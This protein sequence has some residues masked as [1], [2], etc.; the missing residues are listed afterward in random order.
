MV[1]VLIFW[2]LGL[3]LGFSWYFVVGDYGLLLGLWFELLCCCGLCIDVDGLVIVPFW[4][5]C[6]T[7]CISRVWVCFWVFSGFLA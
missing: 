5:C 3:I 4:E 6:N 1:L 7:G 2:V